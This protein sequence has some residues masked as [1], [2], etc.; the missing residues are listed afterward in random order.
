MQANDRAPEHCEALRDYVA[1]GMSYAEIAREINA[2]FGTAYS[3]NA[4]LGRGKRMGLVAPKRPVRPPRIVLKAGVAK[5]WKGR[6]PRAAEPLQPAPPSERAEPN[7][8]SHT[9]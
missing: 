4:A 7:A 3:R 6:E 9:S 2:K 5:V 8:T 1:L